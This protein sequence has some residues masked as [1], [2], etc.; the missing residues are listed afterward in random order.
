MNTLR[1]AFLT[2][3]TCAT[4]ACSTPTVYVVDGR[5]MVSDTQ[6]P[7]SPATSVTGRPAPQYQAPPALPVPPAAQ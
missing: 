3:A 5:P 4:A 7:L 6:V 1:T 2:L